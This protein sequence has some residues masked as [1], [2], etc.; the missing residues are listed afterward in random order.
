MIDSVKDVEHDDEVEH[1]DKDDAENTQRLNEG[2]HTHTVQLLLVSMSKIN[3]SIII[4]IMISVAQK[5]C[6]SF[7]CILPKSFNI[8]TGSFSAAYVPPAKTRE[9]YSDSQMQMDQGLGFKRLVDNAM[10][11]FN[12]LLDSDNIYLIHS[13]S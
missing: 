4:T 6:I 13:V 1:D 9:K 12:F 10:V 5:I 8:N 7:L 11:S 2:F 3:S